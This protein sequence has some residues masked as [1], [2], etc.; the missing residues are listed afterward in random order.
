MASYL[1]DAWIPWMLSASVG[2]VGACWPGSQTNAF[3]KIW[4]NHTVPK[5]TR[6]VSNTEAAD[7]RGDDQA[8]QEP[9]PIPRQP[10]LQ[11][12]ILQATQE[13][14]DLT[15]KSV[16]RVETPADENQETDI[17][18]GA[19]AGRTMIPSF[20]ICA[21]L[22][23]LLVWGVWIFWP[24]NEDRPYLERYTTYILV[25]AVWLFQL[26]R[27]GYRIV[28]INYRLTNRRLFCQRGFY[29]LITAIDLASIATVRIERD[30]LESYLK[31][32]RLRIVPV[33]NSKPPLLLEGVYNPDQIAALIMNQVKQ[34][35]AALTNEPSTTP[36]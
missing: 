28:G 20:V 22:T 21:L 23:G 3:Y 32:G 25:G 12:K 26:I 19:Y 11:E 5:E 15:G 9:A 24:K 27:W 10:P 6:K 13:P 36:A 30:A 16:K 35:R 1:P 7:Q 33:D 4:R 29:T 31:V 8:P 14:K 2:T 18:W 34:T 17:W